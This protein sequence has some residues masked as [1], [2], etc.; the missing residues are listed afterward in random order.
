M[1]FFEPETHESNE[2]DAEAWSIENNRIAL[3]L[4]RQDFPAGQL[5][6]TVGL[7]FEQTQE[8]GW[9][10]V[11]VQYLKETIDQLSNAIAP[12]DL[13]PISANRLALLELCWESSN[14]MWKLVEEFVNQGHDSEPIRAAVIEHCHLVQHIYSKYIV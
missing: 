4:F 8:L 5:Q 13:K 11:N 7:D 1:N 14:A 10:A 6:W 12:H 9:F 3:I 2:F